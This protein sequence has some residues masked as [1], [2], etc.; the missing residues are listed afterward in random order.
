MVFDG[1]LRSLLCHLVANAFLLRLCCT[2]WILFS[3]T[4]RRKRK[5]FL[6]TLPLST[7]PE[8]SVSLV[9]ICQ[10]VTVFEAMDHECAG[11]GKGRELAKECYVQLYFSKFTA[12]APVGLYGVGL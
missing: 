4:L 7:M 2:L 10:R 3:E 6:H 1:S 9:S 8:V 5:V 11:V 12:F